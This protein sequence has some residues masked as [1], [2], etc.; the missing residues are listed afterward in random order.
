MARNTC[1]KATRHQTHFTPRTTGVADGWSPFLLG[2]QPRT[3]IHFYWYGFWRNSLGR[4]YICS[5]PVVGELH[6]QALH[7]GDTNGLLSGPPLPLG[8]SLLIA[9]PTLEGGR[10]STGSCWKVGAATA[11]WGGL[12]PWEHAPPPG[13]SGWEVY[14]SM[15][16]TLLVPAVE[17]HPL[18]YA[19]S[20]ANR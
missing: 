7:S 12:Q 19:L 17:K 5:S 6:G 14:S 13:Q 10:L 2:Q 18:V 20:R 16:G 8:S 9:C 15:V 3:D 4:V 1:W 11:R